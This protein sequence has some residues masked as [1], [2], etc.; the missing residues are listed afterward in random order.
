MVA[1]T[2]YFA[3]AAV[4]RALQVQ[5]VKRSLAE[6]ITER[7]TVEAELR[8]SEQRFRALVEGST[9][10]VIIQRDDKPLF[11]NQAYADMF[12]YASL[13]DILQ[14]DQVAAQ[15]VATHEQARLLG[16]MQTRMRGEEAP[17]FYEFQGV[18]KDGSLIWLANGSSVSTANNGINPTLE[19]TLSGW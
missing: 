14:M 15:T 1:L 17:T 11:A 9:Q 2:V 19:R 10:G 4:Q 16:Y 6:E 8:E 12:G 3:R 5:T 7:R 18:R 13:T